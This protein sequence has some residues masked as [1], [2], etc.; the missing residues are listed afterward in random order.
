[1]EN[2]WRLVLIGET[3]GGVREYICLQKTSAGQKYQ[4]F[5]NT[6]RHCT[7]ECDMSQPVIC[8]VIFSVSH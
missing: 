6:V 1:M 5:K 8:E 3:V 2:L 4:C 7:T